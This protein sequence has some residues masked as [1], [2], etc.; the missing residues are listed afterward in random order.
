MQNLW[1]TIS[2]SLDE[3]SVQCSSN[4]SAFSPS[5]FLLLDVRFVAIAYYTIISFVKIYLPCMRSL[6][7]AWDLHLY[8]HNIP[9]NFTKWSVSRGKN[10]YDHQSFFG[11]LVK[12]CQI[13]V[14]FFISLSFSIRK[15][16]S[17]GSVVKT[18]FEHPTRSTWTACHQLNVRPFYKWLWLL[19]K[20]AS[21]YR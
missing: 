7:F 16:L 17:H 1:C 4:V 13:I 5:L 19:F 2:I 3:R 10:N 15:S 20:H 11:W 6:V 21:R 8:T 14:E 12:I 9:Y 18:N